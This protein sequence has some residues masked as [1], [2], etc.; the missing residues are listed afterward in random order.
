[1]FLQTNSRIVLRLGRA[2]AQ[3]VSRWLPIA[4]AR[5][6]VWVGMWGLWWT[7]Q[8]RGRFSPS[9]SVSPANHSTNFSIII[10]TQGWRNR[11]IGGRSAEWTQ[12]DSTPHYT[13]YKTSTWFGI[14]PLPSRSFAIH[15]SW[16]HP[17][18]SSVGTETN[19]NSPQD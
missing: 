19:V 12:L 15:H 9:T 7:K 1:M 10:I 4:A 16:L 2:V 8:H 3:A 5:A 11:P 18:L 13:N 6:R 17:A 14:L